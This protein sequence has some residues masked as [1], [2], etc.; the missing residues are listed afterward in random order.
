MTMDDYL[1]GLMA[2]GSLP[3]DERRAL[4]AHAEA[5]PSLRSVYDEVTMLGPDAAPTAYQDALLAHYAATRRLPKSPPPPLAELHDR[6][7]TALAK[8][9]VLAAR[10]DALDH[11][12][13]ALP[14]DLHEAEALIANLSARSERSPEPRTPPVAPR[15]ARPLARRLLRAAAVAVLGVTLLY[16]VMALLSQVLRSDLD[17]LA[18]IPPEAVSVDG[19]SLR[20]RGGPTASP[21]ALYLEALAQIRAAL[22]APLGLFPHYE[23]TALREAIALLEATVEAAPL[24]SARFVRHESLLLLAR[25]RIAARDLDGARAALHQLIDEESRHAGQAATILRALDTAADERQ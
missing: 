7:E 1:F 13:S 5:H 6:L 12:L 23:E 15:P 17:R 10:L 11:R 16:S 8:D 21:D 20:T 25:L 9:S 3:P 2:Y 4:A 24:A 22:R 18:A 14:G 19:F